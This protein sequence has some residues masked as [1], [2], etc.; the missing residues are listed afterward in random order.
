MTARISNPLRSRAIL[1][2]A[3]NFTHFEQLPSVK[4]NLNKLASL[5]TSSNVWGI[6]SERCTILEDIST[7]TQLL[8]AIYDAGQED[9]D[10]LLFYYSGHGVTSPFNDELYLALANSRAERLYTAVRF[11]DVRRAILSAHRTSNKVVILDCCF[12]G[13]AMIGSMGCQDELASR[14][15]IEGTYLLTSAAETWPSVAPPGEQFTAFTGELI[16]VLEEGVPNGPEILNMESIYRRVCSELL[17][18]ARPEPQQRNR[19]DGARIAI[20]KNVKYT[21]AVDVHASKKADESIIEYM[22]SQVARMMDPDKMLAQM[23]SLLNEDHLRIR[24]AKSLA[25]MHPE[26]RPEC[27]TVLQQISSSLNTKKIDQIQ[28]IGTIG[29]IDPTRTEAVI[30][31]L[32][33]AASNSKGNPVERSIACRELGQFGGKG[34]E[35]ALE[36]YRAILRQSEEEDHPDLMTQGIVNIA[37]RFATDWPDYKHE[38]AD[39]LGRVGVTYK[40]SADARRSALIL[41]M[42]LDKSKERLVTKELEKIAAI[43]Q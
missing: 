41:L 9:L 15:E 14:S 27:L 35:L 32:A 18:K 31:D 12:S 30:N 38:V 16:T 2:G 4:N 29:R 22:K 3:H 21:R 24:S 17:A 26:F 8:D 19:N 25:E 13:R 40:F 5:L 1:T 23:K 28:A 10:T 37:K 7:P 11:E 39:F 43:T 36:N 34:Q 33:D 6:P 20:A 42:E